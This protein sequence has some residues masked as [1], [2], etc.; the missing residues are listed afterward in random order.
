[1]AKNK[2]FSLGINVKNPEQQRWAHVV[3]S[4][5]LDREQSCFF[6]QSHAWG[7]KYYNYANQPTGT[8]DFTISKKNTCKRLLAG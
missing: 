2:I 6:V 8:I 7:V 1:M 4:G 5:S 3:H